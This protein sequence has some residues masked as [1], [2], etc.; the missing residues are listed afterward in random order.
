M[1]QLGLAHLVFPGAGHSRLEHLLGVV[2]GA[3]RMMDALEKNAAERA[4]DDAIPRVKPEDVEAVR[5]AGLL[6]DI[7]HGQISHVSEP[8]IRDRY[9]KEFDQLR[10]L[11]LDTFVGSTKVSSVEILSLLVVLSPALESVFKEAKAQAAPGKIAALIIGAR[12][13]QELGYLSGIISGPLDADKL[14]YIARDAHHSGISMA[15]G[16]SRLISKLEVVCIEPTSPVDPVLQERARRSTNKRIF[17]IGISVA[18]LSAFDQMVIS[19]VMLHE[20]ISLHHKVRAATAMARMLCTLAAE[21]SERHFS[22]AELMTSY[23]DDTFLAVLGGRVRLTEPPGG[24]RAAALYDNL[25]NRRLYQR[26]F[27]FSTRFLPG[28]AL[29]DEERSA[30]EQLHPIPSLDSTKERAEL[31]NAIYALARKL[32]EAIPGLREMADGLQPEHV[33]VAAP[34]RRATIQSSQLPT[35]SRDGYVER[36]DRYFNS[37]RWSEAFHQQKYCGYVFSPEAC[38]PLIALASRIVLAQRN[39]PVGPAA[40]RAANTVNMVKPEWLDQAKDSGLCSASAYRALTVGHLDRLLQILPHRLKFPEGWLEQDPD[41]PQRIADGLA[42]AVPGGIGTAA[43]L[44]L[45]RALDALLRVLDTA[46]RSAWFTGLDTLSESTL[47]HK[48]EECLRMSE[49]Q[50]ESKVADAG[51][52]I[53][54]LVERMVVELKVSRKPGAD[55]F[56]ELLDA[57]AQARRYAIARNAKVAFV[58]VAYPSEGNDLPLPSRI[59]VLSHAD[60]ASEFAEIRLL[61]PW[62]RPVPSRTKAPRRKSKAAAG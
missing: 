36:S 31:G 18:G 44:T 38:R 49:A 54:L 60:S 24:P 1:R 30:L 5:L 56:K 3:Q 28:D 13:G 26:A 32:G 47:H 15:L 37:D 27:A 8:I 6:H 10:E 61:I 16:V 62:G 23:S 2:E 42:A 4:S 39:F 12:W 14:D 45:K 43:Q 48:V 21:E 52:E 41:L 58:V 59:R 50:V 11:V 9:R 7:G 29:P 53:D 20:R 35:R 22:L 25:L 33:L 17:E 55:P 46:E 19:R 51:G 57:A 34:D 40:D